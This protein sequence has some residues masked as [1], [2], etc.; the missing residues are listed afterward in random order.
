MSKSFTAFANFVAG[1]AGK[2]QTFI[3]ALAVVVIWAVS[4]PVFKWS[5]T[6]Q[7]V[8]NTGTTIVTFLMV[9]LI[10]NSQNRD[11]A[12]FQAKLD[13]LLRA[14]DEARNSFIGI[15]HRSAEEIDT[16]RAALE[17]ETGQVEEETHRAHA[18]VSRLLD[19]Y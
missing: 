3:L 7:L 12:A 18:S 9:F 1:A 5:D 19:R 4:G 11:A 16:L 2:A 13:E 6:W 14:L 15:E 17:E 8:I 10:Q